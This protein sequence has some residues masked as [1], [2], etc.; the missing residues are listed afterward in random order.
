MKYKILHGTVNGKHFV[1]TIFDDQEI[2]HPMKLGLHRFF[3]E[4]KK[5]M[6]R[7]KRKKESETGYISLSGSS[8]GCKR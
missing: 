5:A 8:S 1:I 6:I 7:E 3:E 2:I 4:Y